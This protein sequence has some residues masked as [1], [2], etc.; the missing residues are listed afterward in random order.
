MSL[1]V[2]LNL[3]RQLKMLQVSR[4]PRGGQI[5]AKFAS[6]GDGDFEGG[7]DDTDLD[8]I[9]LILDGDVPAVVAEVSG[10]RTLNLGSG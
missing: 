9:P 6:L 8:G 4:S 7:D 10:A 3:G 2:L 1:L 5:E